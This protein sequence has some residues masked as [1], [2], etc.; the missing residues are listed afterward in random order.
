MADHLCESLAVLSL[1]Q[2]RTHAHLSRHWKQVFSQRRQRSVQE[3]DGLPPLLLT[4]CHHQPR[5]PPSLAP[6]N[7]LDMS[8][9]CKAATSFAASPANAKCGRS[10]AQ[11][12]TATMDAE[13]PAKLVTM[14]KEPLPQT[15]HQQMASPM[16][17]WPTPPPKT[18]EML[19][20]PEALQGDHEIIFLTNP[21]T[22]LTL[23]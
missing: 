2:H 17:R 21:N 16:P 11:S 9:I 14:S 8:P 1:S 18:T 6:T 23:G 10:D 5:S 19:C 15:A 22:T 20:Q 12:A 13:Q 7:K 3:D 4:R